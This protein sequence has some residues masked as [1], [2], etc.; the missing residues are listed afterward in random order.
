MPAPAPRV[1]EPVRASE[2]VSEPAVTMP[3]AKPVLNFDPDKERQELQEAISKLNEMLQDSSR[4]VSF[5]M[6]V[7]LGHPIVFVKNL[8]TGEVVRQIPNEVVV[9]MAHAIEDFKG[10][11]HNKSA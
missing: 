1:V 3:P 4:T 5:S 2:P 8:S 10:M 9:R 11:L 6:D 7:K